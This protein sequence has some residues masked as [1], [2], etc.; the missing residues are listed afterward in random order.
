MVS[1]PLGGLLK[2]PAY[3]NQCQCSRTMLHSTSC[4]ASFPRGLSPQP[5]PSWTGEVHSYDGGSFKSRP[6]YDVKNVL[7]PILE[8]LP[9]LPLRGKTG[10]MT[11]RGFNGH[12]VYS[13]S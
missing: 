11:A 3:A 7:I 6:Q 1:A 2:T 10:S 8:H 9:W 12:F 5:M 4:H 13:L